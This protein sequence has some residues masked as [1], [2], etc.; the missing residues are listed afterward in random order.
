MA[1]TAPSSQAGASPGDPA[2]ALFPLPGGRR[3]ERGAFV[4]PAD[5]GEHGSVAAARQIDPQRGGGRYRIVA[6]QRAPELADLHPHDRVFDGVEALRPLEEAGGDHRRAQL[7][8]APRE[9]L[10]DQEPQQADLPRRAAER[11]TLDHALQ[12]GD[13][14][15]RALYLRRAKGHDAITFPSALRRMQQCDSHRHHGIE[16][17]LVM[18]L[19]AGSSRETMAFQHGASPRGDS[20]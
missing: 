3:I 17:W 9:H 15:G 4:F 8:S 5:G 1:S 12:L 14:G 19:T 13:G 7:A 20:H 16:A 6:S 11:G 18:L 10:P 2:E